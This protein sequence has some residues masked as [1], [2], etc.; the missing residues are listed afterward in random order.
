[1][2]ALSDDGATITATYE[3]RAVIYEPFDEVPLELSACD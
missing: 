2:I 1:V 3:D